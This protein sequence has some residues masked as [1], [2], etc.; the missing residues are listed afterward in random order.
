MGVTWIDLVSGADSTVAL[1][2]FHAG[3]PLLPQDPAGF[4][5]EVGA[6]TVEPA[7]GRYRIEAVSDGNYEQLAGLVA[8]FAAETELVSHAFI[9]LDHDEYGAEHIVI[10]TRGDA[11]RRT[12]HYYVYPRWDDGS[13]YTDGE[14]S[15]T[16]CRLPGIEEPVGSAD[17][18]VLVDGHLART[19]IAALYGVPAIAVDRA[20]EKDAFAYRER[21]VIGGPC[22]AWCTALSLSWPGG[23]RR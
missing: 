5:I 9:A 8:W 16:C 13:Y 3:I 12:Y 19:T 23:E 22:N 7:T 21:G 4:Q 14:P 20:A 10:D 17:P 1:A 15:R 18:G 6:A 11:V 2:T